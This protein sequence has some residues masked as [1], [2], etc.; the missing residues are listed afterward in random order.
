M[1]NIFIFI[2]GNLIKN[3]FVCEHQLLITDLQNK[4]N[5]VFASVT[6]L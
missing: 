5:S 4:Q 2:S 3:W 6:G 1:S